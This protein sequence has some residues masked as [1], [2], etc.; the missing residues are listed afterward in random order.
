MV[1]NGVVYAA[2]G[3]RAEGDSRHEFLGDLD[4]F[5]RRLMEVDREG[6]KS[7]RVTAARNLRKKVTGRVH[8]FISI[9]G[10]KSKGYHRKKSWGTGAANA[11]Q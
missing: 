5:K 7:G 4:K 9:D 1:V 10:R 11:I 8:G 6:F 2:M 3:Y